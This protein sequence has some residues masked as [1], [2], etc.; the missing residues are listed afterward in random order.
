VEATTTIAREIA[1]SSPSAQALTKT[2]FY[3]LD[4]LDFR[5]GVLAGARTNVAARST[6][7]FRSGVLRFAKKA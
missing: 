5:D 4:G 6:D 3:Q 7:D 2:L 1:E